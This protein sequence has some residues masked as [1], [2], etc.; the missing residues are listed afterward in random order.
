MKRLTQAE[1]QIMQALWALDKGGF[2][3]DILEALDEPKP[4]HNT[5]ATLLRILVEK[6]FVGIQNPNRNNF[7]HP[8]VSKDDY[9]ANRIEG[10]TETYFKGSYS[11][12]VS[13]LVDNKQM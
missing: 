12:V 8:L 5:V 11:N 10:L 2:I 9:S 1:A 3:K 13:F 6:R 7:Y 4:H